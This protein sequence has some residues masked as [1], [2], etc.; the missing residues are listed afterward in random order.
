MD[1]APDTVDRGLARRGLALLGALVV[2]LA[3]VVGY[4]VID[5]GAR[6]AQPTVPSGHD[7]AEQASPSTTPTAS[8]ADVAGDPAVAADPGAHAEST[9]TEPQEVGVPAPEQAQTVSPASFA[10]LTDPGEASPTPAEPPADAPVPADRYPQF[11]APGG[12]D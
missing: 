6:R 4:R 2:A 7:L 11:V 12:K 10:E 9:P 1:D 3:G 5:A 8:P